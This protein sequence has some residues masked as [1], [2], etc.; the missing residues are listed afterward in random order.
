MNFLYNFINKPLPATDAGWTLFLDR[1]GVINEEMIGDYIKR[2]EDFHFIAG[3]LEALSMLHGFFKRI[4]V[5]SNQKGVGKGVMT[6]ADLD[7]INQKMM[8]KIAAAGGR[9][10][11][12]Y[13]ATATDPL[14][15]NRKPRPGMA[16]QAQQ[17][18]PD[19]DFQKSIMVGNMAADMQFGRAIGAC[20]V[21]IPTRPD[22][23][24]RPEEVDCVFKDLLSFAR[25][26]QQQRQAT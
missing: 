26:V 8:E 12:A 11:A 2:P 16:L 15:K 1:D 24:P 10:D 4:I 17:D 25:A 14:D 7:A 23:M 9:V 3:S 19:I 22:G 5:V 21:Y 20:T 18:F 6:A 13:Y